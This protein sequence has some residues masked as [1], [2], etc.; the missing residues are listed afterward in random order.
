VHCARTG[1]WGG[2]VGNHRLYPEADG[3]QRPLVPRSRFQPQ[4]RPGVG[5]TACTG[6]GRRVSCVPSQV[7]HMRRGPPLER[8]RWAPSPSKRSSKTPFRP[9]NGLIPCLRMSAEPPMPSCSAGRRPWVVTSKP[10]RTVICP[11]F[12]TTPVGIAPARNARPSRP[13]AGSPSSAPGCWPA[14]ITT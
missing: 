11:A 5:L 2:R 12:D 4:L 1:L 10:V 8:W 13:S 9:T 7:V 6:E 14:I 3:L